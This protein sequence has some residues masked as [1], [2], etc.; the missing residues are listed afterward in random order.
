MCMWVFS[1]T[2]FEIEITGVVTC[3][4]FPEYHIDRYR[5]IV[6]I[7]VYITGLYHLNIIHNHPLN[8]EITAKFEIGE[9]HSHTFPTKTVMC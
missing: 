9:N 3:L 2:L 1:V 4:L 5:C 8:R 6:Y 7:Y